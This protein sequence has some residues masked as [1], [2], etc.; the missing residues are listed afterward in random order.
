VKKLETV[1]NES[2]VEKD[3]VASQTVTSV[4]HNLDTTGRV[5][6]VEPCEDFVVGEAVFLLWLLA[7]NFVCA[8]DCVV[9][10]ANCESKC[11]SPTF[12]SLPRYR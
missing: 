9:I 11:L 8:D 2:Q 10:L 4:A 1:L 12:F 7:V 3:T 5:I 6:A